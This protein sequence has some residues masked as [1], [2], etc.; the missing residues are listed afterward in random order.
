MWSMSYKRE[1]CT[2]R[3]QKLE[4]D[5][6]NQLTP[7]DIQNFKKSEASREAVKLLGQY[8]D[9][10]AS[11]EVNLSA[12]ALVRDF[13]FTQIFIDNAHRPGVLSYMSMDEFGNMRKVMEE[14]IIAVM[15]HKTVYIHG[16]AHICSQQQINELVVHFCPPNASSGDNL[17]DRLRPCSIFHSVLIH[18]H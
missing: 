17:K 12:Y 6:A 14:W 15:N 11:I 10:T 9:P 7:A 4:E 3:W 2:R 5:S 18:Q 8:S 1:S 16:P 13:L